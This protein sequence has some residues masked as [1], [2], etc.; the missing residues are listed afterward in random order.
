MRERKGVDLDGREVQRSSGRG[1]H[2]QD[3]LYGRKYI[4]KNGKIAKQKAQ[5]YIIHKEI[6]VTGDDHVNWKTAR[7]RKKISHLVF[8]I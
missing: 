7:Y 3:I 6:D 1:P 2:K 4:F 5:K 8:L